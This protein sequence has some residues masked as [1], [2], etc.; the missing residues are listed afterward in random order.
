[1]VTVAP[2]VG[3]ITTSMYPPPD[4]IVPALP[5]KV[6]IASVFA[7]VTLMTASL[8]IVL[9]LFPAAL[10]VYTDR[11]MLPERDEVSQMLNVQSPAGMFVALMY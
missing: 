11:I 5:E 3:L 9:T 7:V 6:A 10:V 1:M 2:P 4:G 8:R